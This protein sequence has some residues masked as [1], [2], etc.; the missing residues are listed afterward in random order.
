MSDKPTIRFTDVVTG[1]DA[2]S[3][4]GFFVGWP[5][6]PAPA[7][8]LRI[9]AGS[10]HVVLAVDP[11]SENVVGFITAISDG[12][13]S[14]YIP[15]LEV[16]PDYQKRGIGSEL[17]RQMLDRL[18]GFYMVDLMCDEALRPFYERLGMVRGTGMMIRNYARQAGSRAGD[19]PGQ[20]SGHASPTPGRRNLDF[21]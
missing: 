21:A 1:I 16:L 15:L 12:Q 14:A 10:S 4:Q 2:D 20:R 9:V 7:T 19:D 13:L 11:A 6:P 8:L 5:N 3:L 18:S 17:V